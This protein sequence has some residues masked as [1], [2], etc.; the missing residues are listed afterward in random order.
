MSEEMTEEM[1]I[2]DMALVETI[3][4][5]DMEEIGIEAMAA[6]DTTGNKLLQE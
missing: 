6:T 5:E 1:E 3:E 2:E 4:I